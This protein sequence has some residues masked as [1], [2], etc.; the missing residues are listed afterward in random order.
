MMRFLSAL[1]LLACLALPAAAQERQWNFDQ[2]DKDAYLVFGVADTDDVGLSFWCSQRSGWITLFVP[3][4]DPKL[5]T[6]G[7]V[8]I[9]VYAGGKRF[10]YQGAATANQEAGN[11]SVEVRL[12]PSDKLFT[13]LRNDDRIRIVFARSEHIYPLQE[14]D[15]EPLLQLCAKG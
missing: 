12:K 13:A 8:R 9:D 10:R 14:V 5:K 1:L 11:V 2:T 3:E 7:K 15:F 4:A 6:G